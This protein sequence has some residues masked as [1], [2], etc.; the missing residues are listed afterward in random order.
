MPRH[1]R[2]VLKINTVD[3]SATEIPFPTSLMDT[4]TASGWEDLSFSLGS[5]EGSDGRIY[6]T[7][8]QAPIILWVDPISD[9]IG[10]LDM[11]SHTSSTGATSNF[12]AYARSVGNSIYFSPTAANYVMKM[13]LTNVG[14]SG[15]SVSSVSSVSSDSYGSA[16][17]YSM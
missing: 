11:T 4:I 17:S 8:W 1:A 13:T 2:S 14:S 12:Y 7:M 6:G 10:W 15:S 3:D 16:K 9:E 5:V